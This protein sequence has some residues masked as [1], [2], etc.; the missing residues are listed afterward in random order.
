M[1]GAVLLFNITT[2]QIL[3]WEPFVALNG[4]QLW[5]YMYTTVANCK[6]TN[7]CTCTYSVVYQLLVYI[8]TSVYLLTLQY[9]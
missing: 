5:L 7:V 8:C 2:V 9:E 3:Q 6:H 1:H 4:G